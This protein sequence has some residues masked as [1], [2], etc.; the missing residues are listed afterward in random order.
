M[1][2]QGAFAAVLARGVW[3][4]KADEAGDRYTE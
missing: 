4:Q 2:K 3:F 1:W